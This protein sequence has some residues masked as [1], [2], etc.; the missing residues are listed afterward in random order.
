M[1]VLKELYNFAKKKKKTPKIAICYKIANE[2]FFIK[3]RLTGKIIQTQPSKV[4]LF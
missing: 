1:Y 2:I 4:F 3:I